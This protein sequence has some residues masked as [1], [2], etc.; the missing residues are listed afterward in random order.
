MSTTTLDQD[1]RNLT[2]VGTWEWDLEKQSIVWSSEAYRIFEID[3]DSP[4]APSDMPRFRS[5]AA[6]G[7]EANVLREALRSGTPWKI[8]H[9]AVTAR[10]R[11]IWI[12]S[13]GRAERVDGRSVRLFGLFQD[14]TDEQNA[15]AELERSRI[16]LE[17]MSLLCGIGG[18][19]Y[20]PATNRVHW[21]NETRRIHEVDDAFEPT[22]ES[23]HVFFAPGALEIQ[24]ES[25][26]R[27]TT[28]GI[29]SDCE[30]DAITARGRTIR[31]R[32]AC[33]VEKSDG[34]IT[35]L[36]G[37][38]Q[39]ITRQRELE[40]TLGR[41]EGLLE[42]I[43]QLTRVGGWE[44]SI[45]SGNPIWTSQVRRIFEASDSFVPTSQS[46]SELLTPEALDLVNS[47]I[48]DAALLSRAFDVEFDAV[49]VRGN[50]V[51]LRSIGR[52]EQVDGH[53]VRV[54]GTLEDVT[55][56]R[57]ADAERQRY[58]QLNE[59]VSRL[60]GIGGW[61][62]D[63]RTKETI[64]SPQVRTIFEVGETFNPLLEDHPKFIA[65]ESSEAVA[66][67]RRRAVVDGLPAEL[68]YQAITATGRR[69]WVRHIYQ[70]ER[71]N[72]RAT[73]LFGTAQDVTA[74]RTAQAEMEVLHAR[75]TAAIEAAELRV[76]EIDL[77]T[78]LLQ[79]LPYLPPTF[80][81]P[82]MTQ[83]LS[84]AMALDFLHPEDRA[85][86]EQQASRVVL[87][88]QPSVS[89]IRVRAAG[90][91]FRYIEIRM[92]LSSASAGPRKIL[93]VSRDVTRDVTLTDEL[94]RKQREAE[95]SSLAKSQFVA[96]MSH[97]IRTPMSGV[98][99]MLEVLLRAEVD[100]AKRA[101]A[102]T[103]LKSARDL[104][105][106]LD[107]IV[108][109][110][111]LESR[112]LSLDSAPFSLSTVVNDVVSLFCALARDK[113]LTLATA[114][115]ASVPE[116]VMGDARRVRQVLTNLVGNAVKFTDAGKVE[117]AV[118]YDADQQVARCTVRD[119]GAGIA[120]DMVDKVFDQ[121]FQVDS[122]TTRRHGGSG[123]GLAISKQL[124]SMMGGVIQVDSKLGEGSAFN[125]TIAAPVAVPPSPERVESQA[126]PI[127]NLRVLVAEDNPAMQQILRALLE[128]GGHQ[129]TVVSD[130]RDAVAM[131]ASQT[132][133]A[134]LMDVMMPMMD[135]PTAAQ[136]IREL[137]G[138]AGGIPIIAL[139]AN[140]LV[141]DRDRYLAAGMTDYLSKPI[142]VE[143]LYAAL[144]RVT[145][146]G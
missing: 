108:D 72:G 31:I 9:P 90:G 56:K 122:S 84:T 128:A 60:S 89:R 54:V 135:G 30:Y 75:L 88:D 36:V 78:G 21:S 22:P 8:I 42:D 85:E 118:R 86:F 73:R 97:E 5:L 131:A 107:D 32:S 127:K 16:L 123:L 83:P 106:V 47:A 23:L 140:A 25:V 139:T 138:R 19:E 145:F 24:A 82:G 67:A 15:K 62:F 37:T 117:I 98:I 43:S 11:E 110:S 76:W 34:H 49:T 28:S 134:V 63:L 105:S 58:E 2:G 142:D 68:E 44:V 65:P 100:E 87:Q 141:G 133:D 45:P 64:W 144:G 129:T 143:A 71:I 101:H 119:T 10:G 18:W 114:V 29:P 136:R 146:S 46:M 3:P 80:A 57:K 92:R 109:V 91:S 4:V 26:Q 116:W 35:R 13:T 50:Q 79:G 6:N 137:G 112:H 132:F 33:R 41:T 38:V 102:A 113:S 27:A 95:E 17:E 12:R 70:A 14:V 20:D 104:M 66:L 125:F 115:E 121:F 124:V 81:P 93:G 77:E 94:V 39:D 40:R 52:P 130:G 99:G 1:I 55:A 53:T 120:D 126:S 69:I 59:Q 103:A 61:E 7:V 51:R 111:Q 48:R 96:R 74:E